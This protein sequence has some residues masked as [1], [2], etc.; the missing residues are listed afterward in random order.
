MRFQLVVCLVL[1]TFLFGQTTQPATPP[2]A[3]G[4]PN[5][6]PTTSSAPPAPAAQVG[7]DDPVLTIKG[8]CSDA[9]LQGDAC[10]TVLTKSQFEKLVE[11]LQ[12]SM[13]PPMRRNLAT[14]YARLLA[15]SGAAEKQGLDKTPH[16][17]EAMRLARMQVLSQELVRTLQAQSNNVS[18]QEIQDYYQKNAG[19]FEQAT[20]VRIFVPHT[21]RPATPAATTPKKTTSGATPAKT[22][23]PAPKPP[24]PEAQEK[25][26]AEAMKKEAD[27]IRTQLEKGE[28]PD[29]LEK[30]A[31]IA[32]NLLGN[33]TPT[34]MEKVRRTSLPADH[35]SVFDLK[36]GEL[37]PVIS[38]A[39]GNY[40]YKMISKE[41]VP[42]DSVK[43][44]I[45]NQLSAQRYREAMQHFQNNSELN[46]AYFGP[47]RPPGMPLPPRGPRP[48][49]QEGE[50]DPD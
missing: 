19:N 18:D 36:P 10:K 46:D 27:L 49:A 11:S 50:N 9:S 1:A 6:T 48:T 42:F 32:A 8:V 7:P 31:F 30:E 35:Q 22:A 5:A 45:H 29:K 13:S 40:I 23:T 26:G 15:M 2:T 47:S 16:F 21:K 24:D 20:F 44:E 34:K 28:D 12:P 41:A 37:S 17:E 3:G 14:N 25:A 43:N 39:S 33:P 4:A 38:D